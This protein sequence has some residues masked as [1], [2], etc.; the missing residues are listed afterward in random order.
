MIIN[1]YSFLQ[2]IHCNGNTKYLMDTANEE[3]EYY[4]Y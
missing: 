1:E 4:R 2:I 3:F